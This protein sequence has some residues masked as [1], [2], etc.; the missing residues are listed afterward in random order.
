MKQPK[1]GAVKK[2]CWSSMCRKNRFRYN[3]RGF[4]SEEA[5]GKDHVPEGR[6]GEGR[7]ELEELVGGA[8]VDGCGGGGHGHGGVALLLESLADPAAHLRAAAAAARSQKR[9]HHLSN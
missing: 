6:Q 9:A 3:E 7:R 8:A 2:T 4:T 1:F 5:R